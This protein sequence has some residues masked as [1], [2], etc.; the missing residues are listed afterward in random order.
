MNKWLDKYES[1]GLVSKN[2]L[3]RKV[4]CSNCGWSWKLSD[5]GLDPMT[6]HKCGGDIKMREGGQLDEYEI[7]GEVQK[8]VIPNNPYFVTAT[9]AKKRSFQGD[10]T[11]GSTGP[12]KINGKVVG[13]K[14]DPYVLEKSMGVAAAIP[15]AVFSAPTVLGASGIVSAAMEAPIAGV[16][17][18]TGSNILNAGFATHGLKSVLSGDVVK[19]WQQAYKSGNPWDYANAAAENVMTGMELFPLV[20]P[21]YKTALGAGNY[22]TKEAA[23]KNM[24]KLNPFNKIEGISANLQN[25]NNFNIE[26]LR[27][28]YH[29]AKRVMQPQEIRFLSKHGAGLREDY[30]TDIPRGGWGTDQWNVNNQLPSPPSEI[31]F[32]PDGTTRTVYNQQPLVNNT[33]DLNKLNKS[34]NRSGLTKDEVLAKTSS[35][36][37]DA[38]SKM[39]NSEFENTVLKPNGEIASYKPGTEL[40]QM[41]FDP[42]NRRMML[43]DQILMSTKEYTDAFNERLDLLN[44]I[45]AGKNKSG[46]NYQV[47][48]LTKDGRLTFHTPEQSIPVKLTDKEKANVEWFNRDPKDWL[49]NKAGLKQEG[50]KWVLSDG[51]SNEEFDSIDDVIYA[52]REGMKTLTEPKTISGESTWGVNLNP[53]QWK[54]DVEDIANT[55]YFR[56]I[57]GIEMSNTTSGVFA[58]NVARK[59]TG[60]YESIN[61]YLKALNLGRVKPGFNSQTEFS[62]GAWENFINSGRG[63][64]FYANPRTVYGTMKTLAPYTVPTAIGAGALNQKQRGG[65]IVTNRGQ[66]DYPGQTTI[67]PSN[68]ITMQGV[69]YPVMG[70]DNT[71]HTKMMHPGM[72]YTFPGQYVTE[73]PMMQGGGQQTTISNYTTNPANWVNPTSFKSENKNNFI[74]QIKKGDS[75]SSIS[76]KY[77]VPLDE[78]VKLNNIENPNVIL[79]GQNLVIPNQLNQ[80]IVSKKQNVVYNNNAE[81]AAIADKR[82][83][84]FQSQQSP[85]NKQIQGVQQMPPGYE[86]KSDISK[87]KPIPHPHEMERITDKDL[88][89]FVATT[90]LAAASMVAAPAVLSASGVIGS[91]MSAPLTIGATTLPYVTPATVI[92]AGFG[93]T[94]ANNLANNLQSGYYTNPKIS[95]SEKIATG[96]TTGLDMLGTPGAVEAIGSHLI[97]PVYRGVTGILNQ[98]GAKFQ[99]I[100]NF[101][102]ESGKAINTTF[103]DVKNIEKLRREHLNDISTNY[104]NDVLGLI[105]DPQKIS[106]EDLPTEL[107]YLK[108]KFIKYFEGKLNSRSISDKFVTNKVFKPLYTEHGGQKNFWDKVYGLGDAKFTESELRNIY[109]K[110][111]LN[112]PTKKDASSLINT[113]FSKIRNEKFYN[114]S[115]D[116]PLIQD[117]IKNKGRLVKPEVLPQ[118]EF[119]ADDEKALSAIRA[120]G[121]FQTISKSKK[122]SKILLTIPEAVEQLYLHASK[123]DD[124]LLKSVLPKISKTEIVNAY[125]KLKNTGSL[126]NGTEEIVPKI[127]TTL[128]QNLTQL[129]PYFRKLALHA[130]AQDNPS[131]F[132]NLVKNYQQSF[133][134]NYNIDLIKSTDELNDLIKITKHE[135]DIAPNPEFVT[136]PDKPRHILINEGVKDKNDVLLNPKMQFL[137]AARKVKDSEK[138]AKFIGANSLSTDSYPMFN[139]MGVSWTKNGL[140]T[141][142]FSGHMTGL[143]DMGYSSKNP[144]LVLKQ[145]NSQI[146][147]LEKLT[148]KKF[149]RGK[150]VNKG[151]SVPQIYYEKLKYGGDIMM[152]NGGNYTFPGQYVTE[153]PMMQPGGQTFN[154]YNYMG[155]LDKHLL[156]SPNV[157]KPV[158]QYTPQNN[159][160]P[161]FNNLSQTTYAS[162][163]STNTKEQQF[164]NNIKIKAAEERKKLAA[165]KSLPSD[166]RNMAQIMRQED[167]IKRAEGPKAKQPYAIVDKIGNVI[168]YYDVNH[169]IVKEEK[170]IT[171]E[172]NKDVDKELSWNEF[173]RA[174][175][176]ADK[177][178]YIDYLQATGNKT[179]PAGL[180]KLHYKD[181]VLENPSTKGKIADMIIPGHKQ[182]TIDS[183]SHTY[184]NSGKMFTLTSQY[185]IPSS[186][187][188]HGTG[189]EDRL[190][191]FTNNTDRNLSNGCINVDGK[192]ICFDFLKEGS[193]LYVL[194]EEKGANNI[195]TFK[196]NFTDNNS[197]KID[198]IR[199]ISRERVNEI[200]Q[201]KKN[202]NNINKAANL[203]MNDKE[204]NFAT[205]VAEKESKGGRSIVSKLESNLL[206]GTIAS[207]YGKFEMKEGFPWLKGG[208]PNNDTVALKAVRDF[209][210]ERN[211]AFSEDTE[212]DLD[213]ARM[214]TEYNTGKF[215][216]DGIWGEEY[217][218]NLY[219]LTRYNSGGEMI[220]RADGSYSKRGLWDNIRD[221][222]GSG[223]APTKQMLDQE[224][225]IKNQYQTGGDVPTVQGNFKKQNEYG[226]MV[227]DEEALAKEAQRLN[228]KRVLTE[229]GS[230]IIFDD[231]WNI[232]AADDNP[233]AS[234][235]KG[236]EKLPNDFN[237]FQE[238]N[239]TLPDNLR[240]DDFKYGDYSHYDLYG[241]WDASGKPNSFNDVKDTE[242]FGLQEDGTYHGFSVGNDGVWLKPKSHPSAWMEYMQG[243]LSTDPY[244]KDNHVIQ[245]ED[246]RLQ[247]VPKTYMKKQGGG[248]ILNTGGEQHR[249]YVKTTNRGEGDKG[250]IMVNHP[251]INKGMWDTIDLTKKA[252]ATTI[253]QGVAATKEW[254]RENPYM[255]QRGGE[256]NNY[257]KNINLNLPVIRHQEMNPLHFNGF[258]AND[259]NQ[260]L[261]IGG[262]NP[263]Y[264]NEDFSVGPYMIGVGN[265]YFQKFPADMGMSGTYHVNDN[266]D[267]NM[268]A[269]QNNVNAGIKYNFA[270]GG[271]VVRRSHD[272]KGKTHVVTGPDGTKK[273]F[274]DPNMGE[275]GNSKYGKEAFYARH[276]SNLANNPYFRAYARATWEEGGEIMAIGGQTMMNPITRKDNRNWL[277]FLKN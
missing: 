154:M 8:Q 127:E 242:Q 139:T 120:L 271:Y 169:N 241:M 196:D 48:G 199:N 69:P 183:R 114:P 274:G 140:V 115:S 247:Y 187:A 71:G 250:H 260:N 46:V 119:S 215:D 138:G 99:N 40:D 273:Y 272:R 58:D 204:L 21:T 49:I 231:N 62:R 104:D 54:G 11:Q 175:P 97:T 124:D 223:K 98:P 10:V 106:A 56:S 24:Q 135:Y 43:K 240:D 101:A 168:R 141:P 159:I 193:N 195:V 163:P 156:Q 3:N 38:V 51:N 116:N 2:S 59:G 131:L 254:H 177:S 216:P 155:N 202:F 164:L 28:I 148:G 228:S 103:N 142:K 233:S 200:R 245:R 256:Q 25:T 226:Y 229:N 88:L 34:I 87:L 110:V 23:L 263:R 30:L 82:L 180:F 249:I 35:K 123:I 39:T 208:N 252:G 31:Q 125:E 136:N 239:K 67:I 181:D 113:Q 89:K 9:D 105:Q 218:K 149:P 152:N 118:T 176:T 52:V 45:I 191:A 44:D 235:Q 83:K 147:A 182:K 270:N 12:V 91:A 5:G 171:G 264:Q 194:P 137:E 222:R 179:T 190:A 64:G 219:P 84:Y 76:N 232:I 257:L 157:A 184:G 244:F 173:M 220:K 60:A 259:K 197:G 210:R 143:N 126:T 72:N 268:G 55:E 269:G 77:N 47:K 178:T 165:K 167:Y 212:E 79:S 95:K 243:Q 145:I 132:S 42:V 267:I 96:L 86:W 61:E 122:N 6:C 237:K 206:P 161:S 144:N 65:P 18:L 236:G 20:G 15:A 185:G 107:N 238:F 227:T 225:K 92:G 111:S 258:L 201:T 224:K 68:Q 121:K 158:Y 170:I 74:Y 217:L 174:H 160:A 266:F 102:T 109:K 189:Y 80:Q 153:Y 211:D 26:E 108:S 261:F 151:Y 221:N 50:N 172:S 16:A 255:K 166:L 205:S 214:Y 27:K 262:V 94:G 63:V 277:E 150:F 246:G 66:W 93:L 4:T 53:G 1:G 14:I 275:R 17:G 230:L 117:F 192:T 85:I 186:K 253:A 130:H 13:K 188:I 29:N 203:G 90:G 133:V 81:M 7:K 78:L 265:K 248:V 209:Y 276:K 70:V 134:P 22:L 33:F 19:P 41:T 234:Y 128:S 75:L 100:R 37:K 129:D 207:S 36:D 198:P 251:T 57:P 146:E 32:M 162:V 112:A 73:Y 213:A